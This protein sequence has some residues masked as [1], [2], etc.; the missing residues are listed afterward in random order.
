VISFA[1][2]SW[3]ENSTVDSAGKA[4]APDRPDGG[5]RVNH[6]H[7]FASRSRQICR[8]LKKQAHGVY[9]GAKPT[10]A[11]S[12]HLDRSYSI[13]GSNSCCWAAFG[14]PR[15]PTCRTDQVC[16]GERS[17]TKKNAALPDG[18]DD[19]RRCHRLDDHD[20]KAQGQNSR[21]RSSAGKRT[22]SRPC[23][24]VQPTIRSEANA[25]RPAC[26]N[27]KQ[28]GGLLRELNKSGTIQRGC[29][30]AGATY[31]KWVEPV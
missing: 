10:T 11:N 24:C 18:Q 23:A 27:E 8:R 22:R 15:H 4:E 9:G 2:T 14:R 13:A 25:H 30:Q 29:G 28:T 3:Q 31:V 26:V 5:R 1:G 7:G 17:T 19:R 12:A 6:R 16:Q 21:H 20:D